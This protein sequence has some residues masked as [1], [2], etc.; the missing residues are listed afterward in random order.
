MKRKEGEHR[1]A[2][3][4]PSLFKTYYLRKHIVLNHS[5]INL[6]PEIINSTSFKS[7]RLNPN[8]LVIHHL[9]V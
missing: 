6:K 4:L 9:K 2:H 3:L 1:C 5:N 8:L 7:M